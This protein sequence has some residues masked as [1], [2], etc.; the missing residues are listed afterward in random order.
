MRSGCDHDELPF[1]RLFLAACLQFS[2]PWV[3]Q[4]EILAL[5]HQL[6]VLQ[7]NTPRRA[8]SAQ[9]SSCRF[10][11]RDGGPAGAILHVVRPDTVIAWHRRAF[12]WYWTRKSRRRRGKTK[13]GRRNSQLDS[14]QEPSE[15]VVGSTPHSRG[16]AQ[17]RD[18]G[19]T[20]D[21][22]QICESRHRPLRRPRLMLTATQHLAHHRLPLLFMEP[23]TTKNNQDFSFRCPSD[24]CA[25]K[26]G[27]RAF[28]NLSESARSISVASPRRSR[29]GHSPA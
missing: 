29:S 24:S 10:C 19:S 3:L 12:A 13:R 2:N 16:T 6:T 11:C 15:F 20:I 5:R 28:L 9:I 22:G 17:V 4:A 8:S 1:R 7:K 14:E 18:R 26:S 25:C 27:S 21:R 23:E